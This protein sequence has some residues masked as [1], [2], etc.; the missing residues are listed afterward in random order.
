VGRGER[1]NQSICWKTYRSS[2]RGKE[3]EG[4]DKDDGVM[5]R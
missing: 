4:V 3:I 5:W 1:N 2:R